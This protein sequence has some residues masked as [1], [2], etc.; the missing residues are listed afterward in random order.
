MIASR[1]RAK[2]WVGILFVLLSNVWP[3]PLE[4]GL[5]GDYDRIIAAE[6]NRYVTG[7]FSDCTAECK[8]RC[9]VF[10]E[11]ARTG[12]VFPITA[13]VPGTLGVIT[14]EAQI[15]GRT[16]R[17]KLAALPDGCWN[18]EPDFN[19]AGVEVLRNS[20]EDWLQIR[21]TQHAAVLFA[22]PHG[23]AISSFEA[24]QP[25]IALQDRGAWLEVRMPAGDARRGW[26]RLKDLQRLKRRSEK[27]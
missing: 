16:L 18:V 9:F 14:G 22:K 15:S 21:I 7:L 26:V 25:L 19:R 13:H 10:F 23:K 11:G 24:N 17:L 5:A 1:W 2:A 12:D 20:A 8:F 4:Q 3:A 27:M 6:Q